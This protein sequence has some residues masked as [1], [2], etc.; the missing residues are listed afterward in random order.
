VGEVID[1][2]GKGYRKPPTK[3]VMVGEAFCGAC[4]AEWEITTQV[5]TVHFKC[6]NCRRTWG[7]LKHVCEPEVAWRCDCGETLFWLTPTGAMCRRCGERPKDWA[8]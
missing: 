7:A 4:G 2:P 8:E 5:G 1:L 3:P 6:P